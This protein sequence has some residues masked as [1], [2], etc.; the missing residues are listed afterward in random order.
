MSGIV[1]IW[2]VDG[3]HVAPSLLA[4]LGGSLSHRGSDAYGQWVEGPAGLACHL[5]RVTP[6]SLAET[7]PAIG[8]SGT[9]LVFDGRLEQP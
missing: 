9:V 7:Q 5:L 3:R 6:E 1:G 8:P 4:V 2:N